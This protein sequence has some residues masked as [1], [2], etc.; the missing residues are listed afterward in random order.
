MAS[1]LLKPKLLSWQRYWFPIDRRGL[2]RSSI[3]TALSVVIAAA[4][5][6]GTLLV[7]L[8]LRAT[9]A[10]DLIYSN[11]LLSFLLAALFFALFFIDFSVVLRAFFTAG[12]LELLIPAPLPPA[13]FFAARLLQVIFSPFW[14][15]VVVVLP[16]AAAFMTAYAGGIV[17]L[18]A[19]ALVVLPLTAIP[20]L[21]ATLFVTLALAWIPLSRLRSVIYIAAL[22]GLA[23]LY[24]VAGQS[25]PII[26]PLSPPDPAQLLHTLQV[27]GPTWFPPHCAAD[28]LA[29]L[30]AGH[31]L[32][33]FS[34]VGL[35]YASALCAA[36]AAYSAW[37]PL[38][39]RAFSHARSGTPGLKL[40]SRRAQQALARCLPFATP[41]FR[42]VFSKEIKLFS[43]DLTRTLHMLL[44]IGLALFY[45]SSLHVLQEAVQLPQ[46]ARVWWNAMLLL[47]NAVMSLFVVTALCARFVFP[48]I[49][50]EGRSFWLIVA[51]PL[52][53]LGFLKA[54][55]ASWLF[56]V[57]LIAAVITMAGTMA[58]DASPP[59]IAASV[60]AMLELS[61]GVAG[62]GVGLGAYYCDVAPDLTVRLSP[63]FGGAVY[64]IAVSVL[65]LLNLLPAL[66][67]VFVH[68]MQTF[69][70]AVSGTQWA[71]CLSGS[72]LLTL[73]LNVTMAHA[74][75]RAGAGAVFGKS[76]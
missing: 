54:K 26:V 19:A 20:A 29:A 69:G 22:A 23:G 55:F 33:F 8:R 61:Y 66:L 4:I 30:L 6:L 36:A 64:I 76:C 17:F 37:R 48:S 42:A 49:A 21:L 31:Y 5:Y 44:L 18:I 52:D 72:F 74:A 43:R 11:A 63:A 7:L 47:T 56:P 40:R 10:D 70:S 68:T 25:R 39:L 35:L 59:V 13:R 2:L 50:A 9:F 3:S 58:I 15:D 28:A 45:L 41:P 14:L 73:Y 67:L 32:T 46:S 62:L 60:I 1:L 24:F 65:G 71:L 57:M 12:D 53:A 34:R 27:R 16:I 75:L 51:S 38:Y